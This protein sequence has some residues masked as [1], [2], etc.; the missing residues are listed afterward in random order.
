MESD[1]FQ[2]LL[3]RT[4]AKIDAAAFALGELV[5]AA[6]CPPVLTVSDNLTRIE[7]LQL[8]LDGSDDCL[9]EA[10]RMVAGYHASPTHGRTPR[11]YLESAS[12]RTC[13]NCVGRRG[14]T[15]DGRFGSR[16]RQLVI[17]E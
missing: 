9:T 8:M 12:E 3:L 17:N 6:N 15:T 11:D 1:N 7:Q 16:V 14:G 5:T 13:G 4:S 10:K 2:C